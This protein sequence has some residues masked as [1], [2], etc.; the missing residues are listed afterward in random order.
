M[1]S[2][3]SHVQ[4]FATPWIAAYQASLSMEF[5][6]QEYWR[7]LPFPTPGDLPYARG[8]SLCRIE[9]VSAL[10]GRFFTTAHLESPRNSLDGIFYSFHSTELTNETSA[11]RYL[12]ENVKKK[13][14]LAS[15]SL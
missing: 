3:F 14:L 2:H 9:P 6:R 11:F 4:L 1:L 7:G 15:R 5:S 12:V 10:A 13:S 8:S